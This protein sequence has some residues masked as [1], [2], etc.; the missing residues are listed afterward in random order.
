M[1]RP[2]F[3]CFLSILSGILLISLTD[4]LPGAVIFC[5]S[6]ILVQRTFD[7]KK[8]INMHIWSMALLLAGMAL[9]YFSYI[10]GDMQA[11]KYA[12]TGVEV[13]VYGRVGAVDY[14]YTGRQKITLEANRIYAQGKAEGANIKIQITLGEDQLA[15]CG[16]EVEIRGVLQQLE[17]ARNPG[18]YNEK[19]YLAARKFDY[20]MYGDLLSE[21]L[22]FNIHFVMDKIRSEISAVYEK[23]LPEREAGILKSMIIGDKSSLDDYVKAMYKEAGIYHILVISGLHISITALFMEWILSHF[24]SVKK[25]AAVSIVFI[26]IYCVFTGAGISAVRAV[27]MAS[28]VIIAKI[29]YREADLLSSASFAAVLLLIYEP[30]YAF[31]IGFQYSFSA[32]FGIG[33][34][35][36]PMG[37][38]MKCAFGSIIKNMKD[39][40]EEF[41][42]AGNRLCAVFGTCIAVFIATIPVQIYHFNYIFPFSA[43]ANMIIL[44][45]V[46]VIV[47]G[48][49]VT[50][51][52]GFFSITIAHII[53][54]PVYLL[55]EF[56]EAICIF[57][58]NIPFS[59]I[60]TAT[61]EYMLCVI[62][63]IGIILWAACFEMRLNKR[64]IVAAGISLFCAFALIF[65]LN[66]M[67][68]ALPSV[69]MLD[70]G[71][72]DCSVIQR[73]KE[74]FVVDGGGWYGR[75][76]GRNTGSS[77]L[78]P[79]LDYKGIGH[80]DGAFISHLDSDHATGIIELVYE[81]SVGVLYL[82]ITA[83][84]GSPMYAELY[85]ACEKMGVPI[86]FL[87]K[88]DKIGNESGAY[89][90]V[91]SPTASD[92][93]KDDNEA[94]MVLFMNMGLKYVF[95]G[96]I[97]FNKEEEI[98]ANFNNLDC[99]VLKIAHHGSKYSTGEVFLDSLKPEIAMAGAGV[100][101]SFGHP[102]VEVQNLLAERNIDFYS[103]NRH[104]A[105]IIFEEGGNINVKTML[106]K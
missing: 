72:G 24:L 2:L 96:D 100:N 52:M 33:L 30:L 45:L 37:K 40:N 39:G 11:E 36:D 94:S 82:P 15:I 42:R 51:L 14:T 17:P 92:S 18:G 85:E 69:T 58:E 4:K 35:A 50:A 8:Q 57:L 76:I 68:E 6:F 9:S 83:D 89:F 93:Y 78:V 27:I 54:G 29:I 90:M 66:A 86:V 79:Y 74:V 28:V 81:K 7:K 12:A 71:Q 20:K 103:T 60:L 80:V 73:G 99:D 5:L 104:G 88:G 75:E 46:P 84:L 32:V 55:L 95:A 53:A 3:I 22:A 59:K 64:K 21:K 44:P 62:F 105:V 1:K 34:L 43:I 56:Y 63:I 13:I 48:G 91:L 67:K 25:A 38:A 16:S 70:V 31:D 98:A 65:T 41:L 10:P 26:C 97:N 61:P 23:I 87:S 101:N 47:V 106:E 102:S 19:L 49:F 77:V